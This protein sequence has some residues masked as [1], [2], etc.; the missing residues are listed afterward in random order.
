MLENIASPS[1]VKALSD[2]EKLNL[3]EEIRNEI[4][5]TVAHNGG[6]LASNLG[7]V[8]LTVAL[9]SVFD[10]DK[11]TIVWDVGHQIYAHK[12]LTGR[13]KD[14]SGLRTMGGLSGFPNRDESPYDH[15]TTGHSSASVSSAL[16]AD[17]GRVLQGKEG[18]TI[19]IIGDGSLTGGL[20]FE[21]LN[22]AGRIHRNFIVIVNDNE[23]SISKNVG[24]L[25]KYLRNIRVTS[26]YMEVKKN[27]E[28][29][30]DKIPLI[31]TPIA[32]LAKHMKEKV[33]NGVVD[34]TIFGDLGFEYYGPFDGNDLESVTN[35]LN[36]VKDLNEPVII[37]LKTKK[38][39]GA[40]FA[41]NQPNIYHGVGSFDPETGR[42]EPSGK[43]FSKVF[44]DKLC[45]LAERDERICGITAAM[46]SG[47]G[48][49][50]F[51]QKFPGRFFDTGIAEGHAVTFS[52]GLAEKG[53][54]PIFAVYST[55]L[56]RG[57]DNVLHDI[58]LQN[59][60]AMLAVDRAGIVGE[61]GK[62][63]NGVFDC[64]YL[65]TIPGISVYSPSYYDELE[66]IMEKY[67]TDDSLKLTAVRYPRGAQM[68]LPDDFKPSFENFDIYGDKNAKITLV[69]YGRIFSQCCLAKKELHK[70]GIEVNIVKL[71]RVVPI[72]KDAVK[73]AASSER[74]YFFEEGYT[75]GG[76]GEGFLSMLMVEGFKGKASLNAIDSGFVS[77]GPMLE[78]LRKLGLTGDK[79]AEQI[80]ADMNKEN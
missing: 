46:A 40:F 66:N 22:N 26:K 9:F 45:E 6:H 51:T 64:A 56:Q 75:V 77:H 44:G 27:T 21:G 23:M 20:A 61:D 39:K 34:S 76:I 71:N 25:S 35:I 12:L 19:A 4:I 24:G 5:K 29:I 13:Y 41:E 42:V 43:N 1:D 72:D 15:F 37:H 80:R 78:V 28:G 14:F 79:I 53:M 47:T 59:F 3:C 17:W 31:G 7:V 38:G 73:A 36:V 67:L 57:Y 74:L 18:H 16:G 10:L 2:E 63:H 60:K 30:L 33:K 11:D 8:E 52:G 69:T 65:R 32:K 48:M 58:S 55:F 62:T 70:D 50:D 49:Y 54:L 68:Y